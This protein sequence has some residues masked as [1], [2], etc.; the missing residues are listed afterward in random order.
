MVADRKKLR[1]FGFKIHQNI[2]MR[3]SP[4]LWFP[5]LEVWLQLKVEEGSSEMSAPWYSPCSK[6]FPGILLSFAIRTDVGPQ[7]PLRLVCL[8]L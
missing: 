6:C 2:P 5:G 3:N 8:E 4:P 7:E 1:N